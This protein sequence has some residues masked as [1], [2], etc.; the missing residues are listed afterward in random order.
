MET[1]PAKGQRLPATIASPAGVP[2]ARLASV[3]LAAR[4]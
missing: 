4:G 2:A 1:R 3:A